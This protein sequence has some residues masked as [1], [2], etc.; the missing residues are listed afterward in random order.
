MVFFRVVAD[1]PPNKTWQYLASDWRRE[2]RAAG[3]EFIYSAYKGLLL[4]HSWDVAQ[5][6]T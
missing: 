3:F 2:E 4:S 6:C 5:L 1:E